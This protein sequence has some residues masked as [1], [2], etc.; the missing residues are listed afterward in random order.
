MGHISR[1]LSLHGK[2]NFV[3][4][5]CSRVSITFSLAVL[6]EAIFP[7]NQSLVSFDCFEVLAQLGLFLLFVVN[8]NADFLVEERL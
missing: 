8:F 5:S 1:A 2:I 3:Q 6:L 7:K 4:I